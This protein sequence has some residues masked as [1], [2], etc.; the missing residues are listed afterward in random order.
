M[1]LKII[2][3][4]AIQWLL[5]FLLILLVGFQIWDVQKLPF[6]PDESTQLYMSSDFD[7]LFSQPSIMAWDP[8]KEADPRQRYRELDAPLTRYLLGLARSIAGEAALPVD[9][10]WSENWEANRLSGALPSPALLQAGRLGITLLL[11]LS[12]FLLFLSAWR[13]GGIFTGLLAAILLGSSALVLLHA[14]RAMAEGPL[15]LGVCLALWG[16]VEGDRRPWLAGLGAALA[17]NAKQSG[18]ALFPVG[19][20]AVCWLPAAAQSRARLLLRNLVIYLGVFALLTIALNPLWWNNPILALRTTW[21]AR[22]ELLAKQTDDATSQQYLGSISQRAVVMVANLTIA[23][24]AFYEVGNYRE[25]TLASEQAY[26]ANPLHRLLRGP[27]AGGI[28]LVL[29][30]IGFVMALVKLRHADST[31]YRVLL[32]LILANLSQVLGLLIWVPLSWQRYMLPTVPFVCIWAAYAL[33]FTGRK[34]PNL[35]NK[36]QNP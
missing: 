35:A 22:Q 1:K 19:L 15:V 10:D 6:H 33:S 9:W 36:E 23:P 2:S 28:F 13:A 14:R 17:F 29:A 25:Q 20:L 8:A 27:V 3:S 16:F 21:I 5:A 24:L 30:L 26:L 12:M 18:L 11:P 7:L 32:L 31:H 34:E 4:R